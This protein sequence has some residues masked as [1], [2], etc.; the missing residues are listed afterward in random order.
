MKEH[1]TKVNDML[2]LGTVYAA[3]FI[4]Q[5]YQPCDPTNTDPNCPIWNQ[6]IEAARLASLNQEPPPTPIE[7]MTQL[8]LIVAGVALVGGVLYYLSQIPER[9]QKRAQQLWNELYHQTDYQ[10]AQLLRQGKINPYLYR[11]VYG[12]SI[13]DLPST[14]HY[15]QELDEGLPPLIPQ[16]H[17]QPTI[18]EH[19]PE[20]NSDLDDRFDY[21]YFE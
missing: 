21:W 10:H 1:L 18:I 2:F 14:P 19:R 7:I 15:Q 9:R 20:T 11:R 6:A 8:G 17:H 4:Q 5:G 12:Q 3:D 13:E 16:D